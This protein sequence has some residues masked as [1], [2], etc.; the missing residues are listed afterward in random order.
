MCTYFNAHH[1]TSGSRVKPKTGHCLTAESSTERRQT[2]DIWGLVNTHSC[3]FIHNELCVNFE[4]CVGKNHCVLILNKFNYEHDF[5][6]VSRSNC[7]YLKTCL[8]WTFF[9][10]WLDESLFSK[11]NCILTHFLDFMTETNTN[12]CCVCPVDVELFKWC[13]YLGQYVFSAFLFAF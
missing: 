6:Y 7:I 1:I 11:G 13:D 3:F 2:W 8:T 12:I 9:S 4:D 10:S 5:E